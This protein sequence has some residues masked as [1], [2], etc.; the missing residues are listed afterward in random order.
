VKSD[1]DRSL[2]RAALNGIGWSRA[3]QSRDRQGAVIG[4][5]FTPAL[6]I[7]PLEA[8]RFKVEMLSPVVDRIAKTADN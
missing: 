3:F 8:G 5:E 4:A 2:T 7:A 1:D 6:A